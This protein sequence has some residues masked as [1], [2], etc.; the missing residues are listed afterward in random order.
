MTIETLMFL[1]RMLNEMTLA[2]GAPD[3]ISTARVVIAA[4]TEV[5]AALN[6]T[7]NAPQ[8]PDNLSKGEG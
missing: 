4:V 6:A 3:F 5:E 8:G 7:A 1:R 2:V